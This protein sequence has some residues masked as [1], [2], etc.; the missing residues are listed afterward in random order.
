MSKDVFSDKGVRLGKVY[1]V[2]FD[3]EQGTVA[4]VCL[5]SF[6]FKNKT[7]F[8]KQISEK[9]IPFQNILSISDSVLVNS[10]M[11]SK[12]ILEETSKKAQNQDKKSQGNQTK[13]HVFSY[14][15]LK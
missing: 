3:L 12:F 14:H 2:I 8:I 13:K 6:E 5:S 7:D 10:K 1:D 4:R 11:P 9:T 15:Y